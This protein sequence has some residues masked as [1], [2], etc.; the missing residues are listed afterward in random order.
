MQHVSQCPECTCYSEEKISYDDEKKIIEFR[1]CGHFLLLPYPGEEVSEFSF[2]DGR[3]PFEFQRKALEIIRKEGGSA[4]VNLKTGRGKTIVAAGALHL[5]PE[6]FLPAVVLCKSSLKMQWAFEIARLTGKLPQVIESSKDDLLP[7]DLFPTVIISLD[8][9]RRLEFLDEI[10]EDIQTVIIDEVQLIK[11]PAS[12][13][14]KH[15]QRLI[16]PNTNVLPLSATPVKNNADEMYT[17]INQVAPWRF[18]SHKNFRHTYVRQVYSGSVAKWG[19]IH[20][21]MM[22]QWKEA[23]KDIII[24]FTDEEMNLSLPPVLDTTRFCEPDEEFR[25]AYSDAL[26]KMEELE[27]QAISDGRMAV[28]AEINNNIMKMKHIAGLLKVNSMVEMVREFLEEN[29]E[30]SLEENP[31]GRY[32]TIF[33]HHIDVGDLLEQKLTELCHE[34]RCNPPLRLRGGNF[35][36]RDEMNKTAAEFHWVSTNPK[37]RILIASTLAAGEGWNLQRCSY[38]ALGERQWNDANESQPIGRFE[39]IG[40]VADVINFYRLVCM[41]TLD[42][43]LV[44]MRANK[45]EYTNEAMGIEKSEE[46]VRQEVYGMLL[47]RGRKLWNKATK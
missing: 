26:D 20:P 34:F 25:D 3:T 31:Q 24:R 2:A 1:R 8:L 38:G 42:E 29:P 40:S 12:K 7:L 6:R 23:T 15:V 16:T 17:V 10:A 33:H 37:D 35:D 41:G 22:N 4:L 21:H 44:E 27:A 30:D 11:N 18:S 13:R 36:G 32:F 39:R 19:G 45:L 46:E 28:Q 43:F 14:T 9:L 47:E 5:W